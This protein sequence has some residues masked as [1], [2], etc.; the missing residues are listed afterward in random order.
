ML[1]ARSV[2]P[3][4]GDKP[5]GYFSASSARKSLAQQIEEKELATHAPIL[6]NEP[7]TALEEH[8]IEQTQF[9]RSKII[10]RQSNPIHSD[11]G[12]RDLVKDCQKVPSHRCKD[13]MPT[14]LPA[15]PHY[16]RR[17]R[18]RTVAPD[19]R[20]MNSFGKIEGNTDQARSRV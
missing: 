12:T 13:Q 20:P 6:R 14:R 16:G 3:R 10:L 5:S 11:K 4:L 1:P 15:P 17:I 18:W 8:C 9:P 2:K 19:L 7:K